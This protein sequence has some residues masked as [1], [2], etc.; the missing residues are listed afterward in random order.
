MPRI[1]V[2]VPAYNGAATIERTV[3][4]VLAQSLADWE[5]IVID[6]G[7]TDTTAAIVAAVMIRD[8]RVRLVRQE[9]AGL[10]AAR[11]RGIIEAAGSHLLFLD[12]DDTIAPDHLQS[13]LDALEDADA[14]IA[15]SG[16]QRIASDGTMLPPTFEPEIARV[17]FIQ[18]A[19]T[20]KVA[21]HCVLA[22]RDL[23]LEVGCFDTT[24]TTCE[25]W[26]LWQRLARSGARFVGVPEPT[27]HYHMYD[28]SMSRDFAKL[29]GGA[30][31]VLARCRRADPRV[32]RPLPEFANGWDDP[33]GHAAVHLLLW[34]AV[35]EV[36]SGHAPSPSLSR[37]P[38]C[39]MGGEGDSIVANIRDAL[40]VGAQADDSELGRVWARVH[41]RVAP[42]IEH[43]G[44]RASEDGLAHRIIYQLER[45]FVRDDPLD[46]P[47]LLTLV[48]GYRADLRQILPVEAGADLLHLRLA[49]GKEEI[50]RHERPLY[51][52]MS[53]REV[54]RLIHEE[55]GKDRIADDHLEQTAQ[56]KLHALRRA[57]RRIVSAIR[58]RRSLGGAMR[59]LKREGWIEQ[60]NDSPPR[61]ASRE[62]RQE[63]FDRARA[64]A[65]QAQ[66]VGPPGGTPP[67]DF[68]RRNDE[69]ERGDVS[70]LS[71]E[72]RRTIGTRSVPVLL[73]H[74]IADESPEQLARLRTSPADFEEQMTLL[75]R[76]GFYAITSAQFDWY[77]VR[78]EALPGRPVIITFASGYRDF[79]ETAWPI[80]CGNDFKAEVF[81]VLDKI[82]GISDWNR[83]FGPP[84]PL[85]NWEEIG[86]LSAQGVAFGSHLATHRHA[87]SLSSPDL[88]DEALRSRLVLEKRL[89][90]EVCSMAAPFGGLD[91]RAIRIFHDAGYSICY[92]TRWGT[93]AL[94]QHSLNLPR[95]EIYGG[96][97]L[98]DF[99]SA[100]GISGAA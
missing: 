90:A 21:V 94:D 28:T 46:A 59:H 100:V 4:S 49:V 10:A 12:A 44:A 43:I 6:D 60:Q 17:P 56:G 11:N 89:G 73:Y 81:V 2:I 14:D 77:R 58:H 79:A 24:L 98:D 67:G 25:D 20:N 88:L 8:D 75:R 62:R 52:G 74:R 41:R 53:A 9:N 92:S 69:R 26:D 39:D 27:A 36:A 66:P 15:Y 19:Y 38:D 51:G 99:A 37:M 3:E 64:A 31:E 34:G 70:E 18:F 32:P 7:S 45:Q 30:L 33:G 96:M 80:L 87:D 85:M 91:E 5:A 13:L 42:L 78:G 65:A 61:P 1:S 95:I 23:I 47:L 76:H 35:A 83:C 16:Y 97:S 72:L 55:A 57:S 84:L 82:G 22:P 40:L 63:I 48:R 54:A 93:A 71:E 86:R 50:L 68:E 29:T